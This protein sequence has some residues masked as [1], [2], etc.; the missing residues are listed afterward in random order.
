MNN[1]LLAR[2]LRFGVLPVEIFPD[3]EALGRAAAAAVAAAI[4][5]R[6]RAPGMVRLILGTGNSQLAFIA[7]LT[8]EPG[9]PWDRVECFHMDEY[10]G[11]GADHPASFRRWMRERV[12]EAVRPGRFHYV[13]GDAADPQAEAARYTALLRAAPIDLACVGIG[14]N[15]HLAFNDPPFADFADPLAVKVVR[16]AEKSRRQQIGEKHFPD[17]A[18]VP[19]HALTLTIPILL[20]AQRVFAIV[21]ERRK[22]AAVRAALLGPVTPGCPASILREQPHARLF[23]DA[24]SAAA[25]NDRRDKAAAL[26]AIVR[27][28]FVPIFVPDAHDPRRLVEA[29]VAAGCRAI[30]FSC[31]RP[32]APAMIPW[33]KREFP[34]LAVLAATLMDGPR[35]EAY[36]KKTRA[37]FL[38]VDEAAGL[39]ADA[40]VSFMRFRPETYAQHG[41]ACVIIPGV[42]NQNEALDQ[43]ELGADLIKTTVH[44]AAGVD[45]VTKT[46][47]V[48]HHCI[49]FFISGG[50]NAANLETY[51]Q[52][53][54][55]VTAAG[56]DVLLGKTTATGADLTATARDAIAGMIAAVRAAREK[57][58]PALA[59]AIRSGESNLLLH[60]RWIGPGP[61]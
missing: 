2:P 13:A 9:L 44:T 18:A 5:E 4:R 32:D 54:V 60:G 37:G 48:T 8:A 34:D 53:G 57:H 19:T 17:L 58:Q 49:P 24:D 40:L 22:A 55:A 27:Q 46:G 43:L 14:E 3:G 35:T 11:M 26:D 41:R 16:L 15:G 12:V 33:I 29:A 59:A 38:T 28:G 23:L 20:A 42:A 10:L 50:V 30:E 36:L 52:A 47:A 61:A 25:L 6:A 51:I 56:F 7:A 31:R 21:P 39:G 1:P 45:F